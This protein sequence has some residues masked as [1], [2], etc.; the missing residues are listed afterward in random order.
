MA[1]VRRIKRL[2]GACVVMLAIAAYGDASG[3]SVES[4][5]A[6]RRALNAFNRLRPSFVANEGQTDPRVR[7]YHHGALRSFYFTVDKA[8]LVFPGVA[9]HLRFLDPGSDVTIEARRHTSGVVNYYL[10]DSAAWR[11]GLPMH[12]EVA[13]RELWPGIDLRFEG[14]TGKL[15]Y[16]FLVRPGADVRRIR[17]AYEGS[18]H[19]SLD[20]AGNL[21]VGTPVGALLDERPRS[22]QQIDGRTVAV[23]SRY[24]LTRAPDGSTAHG[25]ALGSDYDPR[26]PLVID[27]GVDFSTFLGGVGNEES[28]GIT[29]GGRDVYVTGSTRSPD[30]P[31]TPG[32]FDQ[33]INGSDDVFVSKL[34]QD[35]SELVYSTFLGG[36]ASD[37]GE[38]VAVDGAHAYIA[39]ETESVDFPTTSRA[40][41]QTF[42]GV[43]DAF[44]TK[45]DSEGG[46]LVY[47]T[48]LGGGARDQARSL[49]VSGGQAYL[50]GETSSADFPTTAEAFDQTHNG[51]EDAFVTNFAANGSGLQYSTFLG[52][53]FADVGRGISVQGGT[54]YLT[55]FTDSPNFP[56]SPGAFD[57]TF[58]VTRDAFVTKLDVHGDLNY[59]TYLG[60]LLLDEAFAIAVH[61]GEAYVTGTTISPEYPTTA[62]AV[63]PLFNGI[64]DVFVTR[65]NKDGTALI[66][67]TFL[68]GVLEETARGI[69][70][71]SGIAYVAGAT[72]SPN[73]PTTADA[74]QPVYNGGTSDA[75][76]SELNEDGTALVYSTYLGGTNR[77]QGRAIVVG[78]TDAYVT[79]F[80]SSANF[81]TTPGAFDQTHN[82]N[83]DVFITRFD[84][85]HRAR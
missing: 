30:F 63:D 64:S 52:G 58:N 19:I 2:G 22:H 15:K 41:D 69:D 8:V 67:S 49:D 12:R 24:S 5:L 48:Y 14:G 10:G 16:E 71:S 9:L 61:S 20:E 51:L 34:T 82:G 33:T 73:Y 81:P 18:T 29:L 77:D 13:Y 7:Y 84:L 50:T 47:S 75:F 11:A 36:S 4:D 80:T 44:L 35:G 46:S 1:P 21:V 59:S 38:D 72:N 39:G 26:Y 70:I 74:F 68:G 37:V 62:G 3:G 25:F 31:T 53:T 42:N 27:P 66:Y 43:E 28:F 78:G 17:L 57:Q 65:L 32:A 76:L 60:G 79:G 45:L 55:G 6:R 85:R 54:A 83:R 40:F 56:T 23:E